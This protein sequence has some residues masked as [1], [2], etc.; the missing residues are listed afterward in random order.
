MTVLDRS[1]VSMNILYVHCQSLMLRPCICLG[2]SQKNSV[3]CLVLHRLQSAIAKQKEG[4]SPQ[5]C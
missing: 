2:T 3:S 1:N 5:D 4:D